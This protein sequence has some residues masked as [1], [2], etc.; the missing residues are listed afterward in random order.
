MVVIMILGHYV[1]SFPKLLS[2]ALIIRK[3][4]LSR[5]KKLLKTYNK[6]QGKVNSLMNIEFDSET[7]YGHNNKYIKPKIKLYKDKVKTN[8]QGNKIPKEYA[9]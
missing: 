5:L 1:Q 2:N 6:I 7:V 8:F 3:Q 4:C 9:S